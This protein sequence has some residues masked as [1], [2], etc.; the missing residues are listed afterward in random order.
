MSRVASERGHT[1]MELLVTMSL[2]SV[3]LGAVTSAFVAFNKNE[4][5]N[6]K[7][8]ESQ[9]EAR[10]GMERVSR[11]LRNLASP[12]DNDPSAIDYASD[13]DIVFRTVDSSKE[14]GS[15]NDRNVKRVRY[16]LS[17]STAGTETLWSQEQKW[18]TT[19]PPDD[20]PSTSTCPSDAWGNQTSVAQYIVNRE[21]NRPV[22]GYRP[23]PTD[24]KAIFAIETE[25]LVDMTSGTGTHA[26]T[27]LASGVFL[28]NQNRAPVS[29]CTATYTG[30]GRQ[31][32]L[33]GSSSSDPEGRSIRKF[34]WL[35]NNVVVGTGA[36]FIWDAPES[37]TYVLELRT[38][39]YGGLTGTANCNQPAV[40][41]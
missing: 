11:Q 33:N 19:D 9:D 5:V 25:L 31:V 10:N 15:A 6:E 39:D 14:A 38:T 3:V 16:C 40:V 21:G 27:K 28:R 1:L 35:H 37:G 30:I 7:Q 13:Y 41:P 18:T 29:S 12:K 4:R 23:G 24:K 2:L 36:F 26:P 32:L 8:N 20:Y 22:F 34:E 17:P